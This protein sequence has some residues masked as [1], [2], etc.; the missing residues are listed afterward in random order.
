MP[1]AK[2]V[3]KRI[4]FSVAQLL[5]TGLLGQKLTNQNVTW[6]VIVSSNKPIALKNRNKFIDL[7]KIERPRFVLI[8]NFVQR[9]WFS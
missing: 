1:N 8:L 7:N 9:S 4:N 6:I 3:A 2:G 5:E